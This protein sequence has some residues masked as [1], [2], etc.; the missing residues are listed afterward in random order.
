M[1][2]DKQLEYA[3][4]RWLEALRNGLEFDAVYWQGVIDGLK[5]RIEREKEEPHDPN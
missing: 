1:S 3:E 4:F 2:L 5:L